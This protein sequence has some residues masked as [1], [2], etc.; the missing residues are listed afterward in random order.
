HVLRV[1]DAGL[2]ESPWAALAGEDAAGNAA[3]L[4]RLVDGEIGP[5]R[6]AVQYSGALA[7]LVAGD[8]ELGD[9]PDL[10]KRIGEALDSGAVRGV[11]DRLIA[12]SRGTQASAS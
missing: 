12:C 2:P 11:L 4:R 7:L 6:T 5:Y 8:G 10:A 3:A 1:A 9:L